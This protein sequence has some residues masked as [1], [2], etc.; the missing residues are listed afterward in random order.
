MIIIEEGKRYVRRDGGLSDKIRFRKKKDVW[1]PFTDGRNL[2]AINGRCCQISG[3]HCGYDLI[4]EY[5]E[6]S[7]KEIDFSKPLRFTAIDKA[8]VHYIGLDKDGKHMC[9]K[10]TGMEAIFVVDQWGKSAQFVD[11]ENVPEKLVRWVNVYPDAHPSKKD[12][13]HCAA[14]DRIA[15]IRIEFEEGEGL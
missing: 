9:Q 13:D 3:A 8:P 12:A 15:C 5:K 10:T 4:S 14:A 7:M 1:F 2:Y 6:P 11:I